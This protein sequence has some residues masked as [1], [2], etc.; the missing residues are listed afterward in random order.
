M[1]AGDRFFANTNCIKQKLNLYFTKN[2][3]SDSLIS[4]HYWDESTLLMLICY[5]E[6][7]VEEGGK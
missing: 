3:N 2:Y 4:S 6:R 1:C 5:D 7:D